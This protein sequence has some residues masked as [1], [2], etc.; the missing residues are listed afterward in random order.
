MGRKTISRAMRLRVAERFG[1]ICA[2][3]YE[4]IPK[5][6]PEAMSEHDYRH[7]GMLTMD[8]VRPVVFGGSEEERNLQPAHA[9]CNLRE[10]RKWRLQEITADE[11]E[12][13]ERVMFEVY[14]NERAVRVWR[15]RE[16]LHRGMANYIQNRLMDVGVSAGASTRV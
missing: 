1:W 5:E 2:I 9:L 10:G 13:G 6:R 16:P 8:H 3:C 11:L 7:Y 12:L 14:R 15:D 4:P